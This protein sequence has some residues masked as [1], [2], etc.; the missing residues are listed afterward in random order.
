MYNVAVAAERYV[1]P[2][3]FGSPVDG[4]HFAD[5]KREL[6][7]LRAVMSSGQNL[8]LIAPRRYGKSSLLLAA[9]ARARRSG[10]RTGRVNL[11]KCATPAEVAEAVLR[12]AVRGPWGWL[13]GRTAQLGEHLSRIRIGVEI[14]TDARTGS[15]SG[16]SFMP[17]LRPVD[18]RGVVLDVL[19]AL[20][21]LSSDAHPVS[22]VLDEFQRAYEIDRG[23]A[24]VMKAA[25]DE[26][27]SLSL[28]FAGSRRHLME[29]MVQ[30]PNHGPLYNVGAKLYLERIPAP[31]FSAFLVA[32]A[33]AGG[34]E[35]GAGVA[36]RVYQL[37]VGVPND[38]QLL[39]FWAF[40]QPGEVITGEALEVA[41]R[42]AIADQRQE[43]QAVWDGLASSQQRLL[44]LLARQSLR[45]LRG[46]EA[47]R[48]L[49]LSP[50]AVAKAGTVLERA[51]LIRRG[52]EGWE[53]TSGLMGEWLRGDY[54]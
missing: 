21:R 32:R 18:W 14:Q 28:V 38:V 16:V 49:E 11:I 53:L 7:Q 5:R 34:K 13:R 29:E 42:S 43:Y 10:G 12:G 22:L 48:H 33:R 54:D 47:M 25:V 44:K 4:D 35:L 45:S 19:V 40:E 52:E 36:E 27:P 8:I 39:A 17:S 41:L 3:R 37:A 31:E 1:N 15:V 20:G 30:D 51:D 50:T 23:I 24:D 9:M 6:A 2:Y 46:T 26:A